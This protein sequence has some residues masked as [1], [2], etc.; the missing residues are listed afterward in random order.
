MK[1]L[2]LAATVMAS[3]LTLG[4]GSLVGAECAPG[5]EFSGETCVRDKGFGIEQPGSSFVL[6]M[7]F[8]AVSPAS[9]EARLLGNAIFMTG[10]DP[11]KILDYRAHTEW[12]ASSVT[13]VVDLCADE[14]VARE[15]TLQT[16]V[17]KDA[18]HARDELEN[19]EYDIFLIHD[20][21]AAE[22]G[23]LAGVG[24][25][26]A[27]LIPGFVEKSGS[28]VVLATASGEAEMGELLSASGVLE[29]TG[30]HAITPGEVK[31]AVPTDGLGAGVQGPLSGKQSLASFDIDDTAGQAYTA[32]LVD[33]DG[34]AV[35]VRRYW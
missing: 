35:A 29:V 27:P 23:A 22:K 16:T 20:Q 7:D 14:A 9:P 10:A 17:A 31:N 8:S 15:R 4:C 18:E 2:L 19:G 24:A 25:L 11:V 5:F 34:G 28:V 32:V 21:A 26:W 13:N 12:N 30:I 33:G 3:G 6:G 1:A